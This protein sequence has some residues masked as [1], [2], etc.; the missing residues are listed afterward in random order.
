MKSLDDLT[1]PELRDLCTE[2]AHTVKSMLPGDTGFILLFTPFGASGIA[3][4]VANGT[5][6]E[7][8]AWL[9]ETADRL[10]GREDVTR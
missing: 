9:R 8:I 6:P 5:R 3:Q 1:E 10:Q 7:C 4:Y 2:I